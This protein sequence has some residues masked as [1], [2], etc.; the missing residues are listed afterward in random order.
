[1]VASDASTR[2]YTS[3]AI[4]DAAKAKGKN[5]RVWRDSDEWTVRRG[6]IMLV[7]RD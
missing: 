5:V 6:R 2:F 3:Q 1:M 7:R 4:D